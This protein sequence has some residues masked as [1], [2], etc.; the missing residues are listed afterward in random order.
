MNIENTIRRKC[1]DKA[2]YWA[3]LSDNGY[4][5]KN[6]DVPVELDCRWESM[7][8]LETAKMVT[9][10]GE[11]LLANSKVYLI[12]DVKEQG[13]LYKGTLDTVSSETNPTEMEGAFEIK[14]FEKIPALGSTTDFVRKAY[15]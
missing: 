10:T 4:G 14:K 6:F 2:V 11:V 13:Y 15:L 12:D 5:G 9:F 1:K 8:L 3:V 7:T